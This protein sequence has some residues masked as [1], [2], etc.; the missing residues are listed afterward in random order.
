[1]KNPFFLALDVKDWGR[2]FEIAQELAPMVGGFKVG[3]RLSIKATP[4]DW[5]KLAGLGP[6]FYDPKFHDIPNT[7]VESIKAC[8]DKGISY[9]TIHAGSGIKA[10]EQ[11]A[12]LENEINQ[13]DF[14]KVLCVTV[15]TSFDSESNPIPG[16]HN[17]NIKDV[18]SSLAGLVNQSG[19]SGLVC[20]GN[21]VESVKAQY[22]DMFTVV[23]GIRLLEDS[24]N[25]QARVLEPQTALGLGADALV[26][27]RSVVDEI[28]PK[29]K[30]KKYL[31]LIADI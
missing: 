10:M 11:I 4:L 26:I 3:P 12:K 22:P 25:D 2:A 27:G 13:S 17:E 21:E 23:P 31:D 9:V 7:M 29:A 24:A 8:A 14:F 20:S 18:V 6:V 1:M 5:Q 19:L 16:Y 15:L 28:Y 30:L